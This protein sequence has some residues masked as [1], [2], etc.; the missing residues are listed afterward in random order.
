MEQI[1]SQQDDGG[2]RN[3]SDGEEIPRSH[4]KF[5]VKLSNVFCY[6]KH[7]HLTVNMQM[8]TIYFWKEDKKTFS[9]QMLLHSH[10]V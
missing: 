1:N 7:N 10:V 9:V 8:Q 6:K 3:S 4:N 2:N 5:S